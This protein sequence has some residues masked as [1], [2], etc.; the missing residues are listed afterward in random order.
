MS[1][2]LVL[3]RPLP[4]IEENR[5]TAKLIFENQLEGN[6]FKSLKEKVEKIG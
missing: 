6:Y 1:R 5:E 2:F 4:T 3:N